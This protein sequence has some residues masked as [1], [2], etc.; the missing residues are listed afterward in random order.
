[1]R[2]RK[3][4]LLVVGQFKRENGW[5]GRKGVR[6]GKGIL[7]VVEKEEEGF[8]DVGSSIHGRVCKIYLLNSLSMLTLSSSIQV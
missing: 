3:L 4:R 6:D 2:K 7:V 5:T 8:Q 1:M